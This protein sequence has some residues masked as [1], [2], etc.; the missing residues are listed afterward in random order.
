MFEI[1]FNKFF[2]LSF[3]ESPGSENR[4]IYSK[5]NLVFKNV[6]KETLA[7][8]DDGTINPNDKCKIPLNTCMNTFLLLHTSQSKYRLEMHIKKYHKGSCLNGD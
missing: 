7:L 4:K 5:D 6:D 3:I 8:S 2:I 1:L